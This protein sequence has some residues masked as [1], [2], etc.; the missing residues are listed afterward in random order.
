MKSFEERLGRLELLSQKLKDGGCSLEEAVAMFEEGIQLARSL[1]KEL[2]RIERRIEIMVNEPEKKGEEPAL[3][4]FPDLS[5]DGG[6]P[7]VPD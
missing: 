4:L 5:E 3:E 7:P 6:S 2:S 1:E